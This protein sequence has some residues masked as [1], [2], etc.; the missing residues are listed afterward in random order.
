MD[1]VLDN[2]NAWKLFIERPLKPFGSSGLEATEAA[3][4]KPVRRHGAVRYSSASSHALRRRSCVP[5]PHRNTW[6][7]SD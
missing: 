6:T 2:L 4:D 3:S 7:R 5:N 1:R